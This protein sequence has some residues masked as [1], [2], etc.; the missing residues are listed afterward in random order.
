MTISIWRY[1]HLALAV[2][3]FVFIVLASLTGVIL[4]FE[5]I[6][7]QVQPYR[8]KDFDEVSL[9]ETIQHLKANYIEILNVDV[10]ANGFVSAVVITESGDAETFYI[11]PR[12]GHKIGD[13]IEKAP[14]FQWTTNFHRS[15]FLK[16]T[17]RIFIGVTSFLLFLIAVSGTVLIVKR[18]R[19]FKRFFSKIVNENFSQYYHVVLGRLSLIPIV[20]ITLTGVYLS[21][22]RFDLL[23]K[24]TLTH[25]VDFDAISETPKRELH[26]QP[27]FRDT[28]LSDVRSVEFPFSE[29]VED[30]YTLQLQDREVLVNQYTGEIL[31]ESK[32]PF[33]ALASRLSINLHTGQGSIIW[34]LI[35]AV[36]CLNIL[37][38]V[39]SG[40]V[41]TFK[42]RKGKLK[43]KFKK[44]NAKFVILI[45]SENGS[46]LQYAN[47]LHAQLLKLGESSF[48]AELNAFSTYKQCEHLVVITATYGQGEAP[49]NA[50]K[51]NS[52]FKTISSDHA[53]SFSVVGFGSLAYKDFC[54][55]AFDVDTL[56]QSDPN[57]V[58]LLAPFTI[59][60]KSFEAYTQWINL[61]SKKVGLQIKLDGDDVLQEKKRKRTFIV[62]E[63]TVASDN[64]DDTFTMVLKSKFG[65]PRFKSGDLLAIQPEAKSAERLYSV[66]KVNQTVFLSVKRQE[67]GL[68]SNFLN[69]LKPNDVIKARLIKNKEFRISKRTKHV[70]MIAN[71]TGI[72]PFVGMIHQSATNQNMQLY[73]G[74]RQPVSFD[75]YKPF[76]ENSLN[77]GKLKKLEIAYSQNESTKVYV[78]HVLERD[79]EQVA[80]VL[81]QKG[82]ILIC[83]SIA[84][85]KD[86]L[87]VL[88]TICDRYLEYPLSVYKSNGQLKLDCY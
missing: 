60:N 79:A 87:K 86:V 16:S 50:N 13:I 9:A 34:A 27:I 47:M 80:L 56:L 82:V 45:G 81:K 11:D 36:A 28:K 29:F 62:L 71:G 18:Q 26:N 15:L 68:C 22:Y 88:E 70:L 54:K 53:Y 66:G 64:P 25:N 2:S 24:E 38:F 85:Q 8:V 58:Q 61:W 67:L 30:C 55:Y 43:N 57:A 48:I 75:I 37:F 69:N 19:S 59:H 31:S 42:R 1:S 41:M 72:A 5:P 7:N 10:D 12:T 46:T 77:T 73:W 21:L 14:L 4:A 20:V 17:G 49:E 33:I 83:G 52:I 32:Y 6:S 40:F 3:S 74:G 23:P 76:I 84:M 65:A 63:K 51:F 78:Q 44:D 39:Y 35:L